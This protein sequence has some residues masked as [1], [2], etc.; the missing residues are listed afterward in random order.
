MN[1]AHRACSR[2]KYLP[3]RAPPPGLL[4][5]LRPHPW[6]PLAIGG[7]RRA[8]TNLALNVMKL[9][10]FAAIFSSFRID[11]TF[12]PIIRERR[13]CDPIAR[14]ATSGAFFAA[15]TTVSSILGNQ[16]AL[17]RRFGRRNMN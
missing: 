4:A 14:N 1:A 17:T 10:G 8:K 3:S 13:R 9:A 12:L 7:R 16:W 11:D 15:E 6:A 5:T 2:S